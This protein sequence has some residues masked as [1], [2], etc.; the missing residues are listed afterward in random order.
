MSG[1]GSCFLL[2]FYFLQNGL[3]LC[4]CPPVSALKSH[5]TLPSLGMGFWLD[6]GLHFWV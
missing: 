6:L 5:L 2:F 1:D 4:G 3:A